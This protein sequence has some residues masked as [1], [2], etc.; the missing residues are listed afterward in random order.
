MNDVY[1]DYYEALSRLKRNKPIRVRKNTRISNDAVA[2]EAGRRK[3]SIKKS[4]IGF[5]TLINDIELAR[6]EQSSAD[7]SIL[8]KM[9][10]LKDDRD[11]YRKLYEEGIT[12]E[13]SLV[14][15]I[16]ELTQTTV[17]SNVLPIRK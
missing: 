2:L 6:T 3:G 17:G 1:D 9:G 14:K 7:D 8:I 12:R 5:A 11:K 15:Q 16:F 4:R 13:V 10:K